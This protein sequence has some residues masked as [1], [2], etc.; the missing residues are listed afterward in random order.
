MNTVRKFVMYGPA[1]TLHRFEDQLLAATKP[2]YNFSYQNKDNDDIVLVKVYEEH[3]K[4]TNSSTTL[5]LLVMIT[6]DRLAL[7]FVVTGGRLGFRGSP[8]DR[9]NAEPSIQDVVYEFI[10]EFS[11]R[12]GLTIQENKVVEEKE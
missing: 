2:Q 10:L 7:D 4:L 5:N 11:E 12:H 8:A 3:K 9:N 1:D 6:G